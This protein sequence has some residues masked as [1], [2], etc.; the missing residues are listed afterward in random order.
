MDADG[1]PEEHELEKIRT[2]PI[3][4]PSE[5]HA[6]V[7]YVAERWRWPEFGWHEY[8]D[9]DGARVFALSTGGW[10]G[11]EDLIAAMR[12]NYV[13]WSFCWIVSRSGGHY[14]FRL[15]WPEGK[16]PTGEK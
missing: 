1:Y 16:P 3:L 13:W 6:L 11:N 7:D 12:G 4:N 14:L 9:R 2:W 8:R 15:R 5:T 10:S